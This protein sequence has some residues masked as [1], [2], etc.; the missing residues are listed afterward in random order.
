MS[1]TRQS[2]FT[3][4]ELAIVM[5]IIGLLIAGILKGQEMVIN[6][7]LKGVIKEVQSYRAAVNTFRDIY[8][9]L[10][11]DMPNAGARI[12][13]CAA[14]VACVDA[15]GNG[16][17][18]IGRLTT[19]W[20]RDNQSALITEPTQFWT[21]LALADLITG[22]TATGQQIW[23]D[24]Y[25]ASAI[26]GGFQVAFVREGGANQAGGHYFILR[27]PP[28]GDPHPTNLGGGV[29]APIQVQYLDKK[30]DNG[31]PNLGNVIADDAANQCWNTGTLR[32]A[33][34][35]QGIC[36]TAFKF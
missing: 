4:V 28:T 35:Q 27:V 2:G 5:I 18:R 6:A 11:G 31:V 19:N 13:N 9:A 1:K 8:D 7:Q 22:I 26:G 32:Y 21:H 12:P 25:P 36:I 20:S 10:P 23:G 33:N 14:N 29:L 16:D 30:M 3:L 17:R 15:G 34:T 24:L